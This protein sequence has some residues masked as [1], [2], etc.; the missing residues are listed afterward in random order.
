MSTGTIRRLDS[1]GDTLL[2]EWDT[3]SD[4]SVEAARQVFDAEAK[5]GLM[6]RC[7]P[8]TNLSGEQI[9]SF[10]PEAG[11]VLAFGRVVGG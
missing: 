2:A 5:L 6:C 10:D 4:A 7:D 11:D 1:T 8:G 9:T 3:T